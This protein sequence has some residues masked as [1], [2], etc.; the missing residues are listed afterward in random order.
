MWYIHVVE[1]YIVLKKK[2]V[3][4]YVTTW[5]NLEDIMLHEINQTQRGKYCLYEVHKVVKHI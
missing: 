2:S 4:A 5:L 3:L 1:Y